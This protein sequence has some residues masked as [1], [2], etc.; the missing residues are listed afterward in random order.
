[1][2]TLEEYMATKYALFSQCFHKLLDTFS[3]WKLWDP[4][5]EAISGKRANNVK[6]GQ[7]WIIN[8]A[9]SDHK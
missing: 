5:C 7:P 9:D 4:I 6:V 2:A 3:I 8:G 1:M